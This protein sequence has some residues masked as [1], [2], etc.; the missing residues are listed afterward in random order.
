MMLQNCINNSF[1]KLSPIESSNG[2]VM[3]EGNSTCKHNYINKL[4]K[5]GKKIHGYM[6]KLFLSP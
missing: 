2:I 1:V 6:Y 4:E 5:I 3:V